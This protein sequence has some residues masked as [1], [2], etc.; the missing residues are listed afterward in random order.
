[1]KLCCFLSLHL[2]HHRA[3]AACNPLTQRSSSR[4]TAEWSPHI[5]VQEKQTLGWKY[6][7]PENRKHRIPEN[8]KHLL[9]NFNA[10]DNKMK[11]LVFQMEPYSLFSLF[12]ALLLTRSHRAPFGCDLRRHTMTDYRVDQ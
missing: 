3:N 6:C 11:R 10:K 2:E 12:S 4:K 5:C 8:R 7:I 1:M 9:S